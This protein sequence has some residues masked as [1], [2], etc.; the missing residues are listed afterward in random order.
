MTDQLHQ[1]PDRTDEI[2]DLVDDLGHSWTDRDRDRHAGLLILVSVHGEPVS[3]DGRTGRGGKVI[4]SPMACA[5]DVVGLLSD[6]TVGAIA[7]E[8]DLRALLGWPRIERS[9]SLRSL[10]ASL[11]TIP[12]LWARAYEHRPDHWLISRTLVKA[13]QPT[14]R[15]GAVERDLRSWHR[16]CRELLGAERRWTRVPTSCS[17][18][19]ENALRQR[20]RDGSVICTRC[21]EVWAESELGWLADVATRTTP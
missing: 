3:M 17:A 18:C 15:P 20:P 21:G 16:Q 5:L 9:G 6:V 13:G 12:A 2:R 4:G 14:I 19:G 10:I 1:V 7:H 11:D 8:T